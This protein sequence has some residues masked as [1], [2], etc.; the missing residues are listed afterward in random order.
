MDEAKDQR[1]FDYHIDKLTIF[2]PL[3]QLYDNVSFL[4]RREILFHIMSSA[5][6]EAT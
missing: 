1:P 4:L 6:G 3:F 5:M 2:H